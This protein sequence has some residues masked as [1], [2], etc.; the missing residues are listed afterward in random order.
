MGPGTGRGAA[1]PRSSGCT[2]GLA[3]TTPR[4]FSLRWC[5]GLLGSAKRDA[6]D[7]RATRLSYQ[8]VEGVSPSL[9]AADTQGESSM[10]RFTSTLVAALGLVGMSFV[11]G[12]GGALA[13]QDGVYPQPGCI[14][15][16]GTF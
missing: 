9:L 2:P 11:V 14:G 7:T 1:R 6:R 12:Q 5:C 16:G 10:K 4:A 13:T 3:P 8:G 15:P